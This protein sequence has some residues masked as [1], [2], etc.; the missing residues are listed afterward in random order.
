[1]VVLSDSSDLSIYMSNSTNS[2]VAISHVPGLSG[3][4]EFTVANCNEI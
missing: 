1:M 3:F 2:D 4:S